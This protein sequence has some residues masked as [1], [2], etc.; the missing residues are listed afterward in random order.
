V[1]WN[2]TTGRTTGVAIRSPQQDLNDI[3]VYVFGIN[4]AN[5]VTE[6]AWGVWNRDSDYV[7]PTDDFQPMIFGDNIPFG[8]QPEEV[9]VDP[10]EPG[11]VH[12]RFEFDFQDGT[13]C[14]TAYQ[15]P[16]NF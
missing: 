1:T 13:T 9:Q 2:P 3:V 15:P 4:V 6:V 10:F 7:G 5:V 14:R 16:L 12:M 8:V 11:V